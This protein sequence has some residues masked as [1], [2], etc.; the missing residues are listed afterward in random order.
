[1]TRAGS[2]RGRRP[3]RCSDLDLLVSN[4]GREGSGRVV[5]HDEADARD[6]FEVHLWGPWRLADALA[7]GIG[8][9]AAG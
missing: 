8:E 6:L 5:G 7:P 9:R 4:A 3:G 1:M 2:R